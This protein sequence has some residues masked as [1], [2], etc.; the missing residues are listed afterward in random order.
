VLQTPRRDPPGRGSRCSATRSRTSRWTW[1]HGAGRSHHVAVSHKS[2]R[3]R[4]L[5]PP[6]RQPLER[7]ALPE[8]RRA[9][10]PSD[11]FQP[12]V[13]LGGR[14]AADPQVPPVCCP[15]KLGRRHTEQAQR[16]FPTA[17]P[18]C[19]AVPGSRPS[20]ASGVR[21]VNAYYAVA[22]VARCAVFPVSPGSRP[23][24]PGGRLRRDLRDSLKA[25]SRR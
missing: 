14:D 23:A 13:N 16:C 6:D 8:T 1:R 24:G 19:I 4:G 22:V 18:G 10:H 11:G 5:K 7:R 25:G 9:E 15:A 2:A 20:S 21:A 12:S 3:E 17:A